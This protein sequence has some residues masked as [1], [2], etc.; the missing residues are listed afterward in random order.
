MKPRPEVD[1][2]MKKLHIHKLRKGQRNP[3]NAILDGHDT[4]L[5]APT[6]FGKSLVYQIPAVILDG[7]TIVIEPLIALMHDQCNKLKDLDIPAAYIDSTL[8]FYDRQSI[9][10]K[11]EKGRIKVLYIS[12]ERLESDILRGIALY[13]RISMVVIDEC[14]CVTMW[15]S[16]FRK[17]YLSI[18][19]H[20]SKLKY[21]PVV[22]A[23]SASI[24]SE[25]IPL[26]T[27]SLSMCDPKVIRKPL[28]RRNLTFTKKVVNTRAAQKKMLLQ[29]MKKHH[30]HTTIIFCTTKKAAEFVVKTIQSKDN[31]ANEVVVYHSSD[32]AHEYEMLH[33]KKHIIVATSA[34]SLGVDIPGVDL[35]IHFN[36]PL[37]IAE[38][39]QMAGRA[40]REGQKARDI[41]IYN[42]NDYRMNWGLL[43]D[44]KDEDV[45]S[46]AVERLD[47]MK[48]FCEDKDN[49][50]VKT[51]LNALG[52]E[53]KTKCR[54]CTN[55]QKGR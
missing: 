53:H 9:M 10:K 7:M 27:E 3:I 40:G 17:S 26:I 12:P 8:S 4:M 24:Y 25:D 49:C 47:A 38:Y 20:I 37:S 29:L 15:G 43:Q 55:C 33:G 11:I 42:P 35:V 1:I 44:I 19:K 51:M 54:Y 39:C 31:Y 50:M 21:H 18:G 45:R 2:A 36:F 48:E 16:A 14:H 6:N 5:I 23:L 32:K 28:Y 13:N 22:V 46:I 41:L 52:D 30:E 34:L